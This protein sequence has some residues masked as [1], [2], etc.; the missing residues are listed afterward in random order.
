M[1]ILMSRPSRGVGDG[2]AGTLVRYIKAHRALG[3]HG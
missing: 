3:T 2:G 1:S